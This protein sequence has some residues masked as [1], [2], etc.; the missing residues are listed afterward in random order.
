MAELTDEQVKQ[1]AEISSSTRTHSLSWNG[2]RSEKGMDLWL[3]TMRAAA[4]FLQLPWD[5]PSMDEANEI[6]Q[7]IPRNAPPVDQLMRALTVFVHR[8]NAALIPKPF[9]PRKE[10]IVRVL[11]EQPKDAWYK[12]TADRILAA[13]DEVK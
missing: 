2:P 7:N 5:E 4:P 10:V 6:E 1:A 13:L 8:R 9:D 11:S 12:D 3:S